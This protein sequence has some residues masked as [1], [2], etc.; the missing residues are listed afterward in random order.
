MIRPVEA[1]L[2]WYLDCA[3][4]LSRT[5]YLPGALSAALGG[6]TVSGLIGVKGFEF[7]RAPL[8][9]NTMR[10]ALAHLAGPRFRLNHKL[11]HAG[12]CGF[13]VL[14]EPSPSLAICRSACS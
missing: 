11:A 13:T 7:F 12:V 14:V 6:S 5:R 1:I 2:K 4:L 10:R 8:V 9:L 3:Q